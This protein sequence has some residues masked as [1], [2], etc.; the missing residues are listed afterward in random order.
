MTEY[1]NIGKL[2]A[3]FGVKGEMLLKHQ[4]GKKT[5]LAGL[6]AL[7]IETRKDQ[8]LPYFIVSAR[9]KSEDE[10]YVI[11]EG[12]ENREMTLPLL[13]KQVWL[14]SDRYAEYADSS[15]PGSLLGFHIMQKGEDIGEILEVIEQP[16]QLLCRVLRNGKDALIPLHEE[17]LLKIDKRKKQVIVQLPDGLLE[18]FS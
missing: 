6:D 11:L 8:L 7:F 15:A 18:I 13:Q 3:S 1:K 10:V 12:I 5:A 2:V 14:N 16:Q 9:A 4:L 17:T